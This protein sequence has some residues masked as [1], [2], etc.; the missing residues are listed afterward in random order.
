MLANKYVQMLIGRRDMEM[1]VQQRAR[2][3]KG[4]VDLVIG[5]IG[6]GMH[7]DGKMSCIKLM[8][9]LRIS[10]VPVYLS[11]SFKLSWSTNSGDIFVTKC[12]ELVIVISVQ[13]GL[14]KIKD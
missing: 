14:C 2:A 4:L 8:V 6:S 13:F 5:N 3:A 12:T 10:F 9:Y 7:S 11:C 1:G